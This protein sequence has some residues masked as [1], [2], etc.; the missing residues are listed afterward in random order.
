MPSEQKTFLGWIIDTRRMR[1]SLP[2]LKA[3][4]WINEID[5]LLQ[6][7]KIKHKDL[8]SILGK[9]NHAAFLISLSRN[10]LN[11]IRHTEL[12]SK[13][14]GPQK[15]S[16]G[17]INDFELFKN[18]LSI[19]NNK[20]TSI[21]N[22]T[23][24]LPDIFC[25]SDACEYG[26]GGY[27]SK[28]EAWQ[29]EIPTHLRGKFSINLLEFL[30]AVVT[31]VISLEKIKQNKKIFALTDNSSALVWLSKASFHPET[32][33]HRNKIARYLATF[34]LQEERSLYAEH[35]SGMHI[36]AED[37]INQLRAACKTI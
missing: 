1:L 2:K 35:I 8:E 27:N 33:E 23:H 7:Q 13:K 11:R 14:F 21:Q 3:F 15:L 36:S 24:S 26:I 17:V 28:G 12:L 19:M 25:W 10:F 6:K 30:A 9:L 29:W 16:L 4:R 20:G 31:I 34:I 5:G 37:M 22:I 32:K 18:L